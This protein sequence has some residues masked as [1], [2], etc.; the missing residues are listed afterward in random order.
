MIKR[1]L[2]TGAAAGAT[3]FILTAAAQRIAPETRFDTIDVQRINVREPDGTLRFTLSNTARFPGLNVRGTEHPHAGRRDK[4]GML[5]FNDEGTENGGLIWNGRTLD[6]ITRAGASLTLDAYE[7]DQ[8]LQLLQT[9]ER[10]PEGSTR[11]AALIINDMPQGPLDPTAVTRARA[12]ATPQEAEAIMRSGNVG[13]TPRMFVGRSRSGNAAIFMQDGQGRPR[14]TMTVGE[15]GAAA[16]NFL[17][18][19]G[20]PVRTITADQ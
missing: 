6:G 10:G 5:F 9:D 20:E 11:T 15:D 8:V 4:A 13:G 17:N 2:L 19:A 14:I 3:L 7:Q 12:A 16:I 18:E 1:A